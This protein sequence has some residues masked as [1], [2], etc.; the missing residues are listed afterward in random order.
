[1]KLFLLEGS[2]HWPV[3]PVRADEGQRRTRAG[4]VFQASGVR[5]RYGRA[6]VDISLRGPR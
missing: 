5:S 6:D 3:L 4:N 2:D 1:M